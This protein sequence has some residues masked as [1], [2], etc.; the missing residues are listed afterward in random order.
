[1][2]YP[3]DNTPPFEWKLRKKLDPSYLECL[4]SSKMEVRANNKKKV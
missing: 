4:A 2:D 1:M 3:K